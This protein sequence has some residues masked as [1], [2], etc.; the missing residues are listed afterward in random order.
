[1][2]SSVKSLIQA[3]EEAKKIVLAAEKEKNDRVRDAA[4]M[5]A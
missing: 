4:T 2:E 5:A 1:M 3:E